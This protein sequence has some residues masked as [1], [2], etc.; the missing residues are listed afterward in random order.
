MYGPTTATSTSVT[1]KTTPTSPFRL[2]SS[3][4][5]VAMDHDSPAA[6]PRAGTTTATGGAVAVGGVM[7]DS[8]R[9]SWL[10]IKCQIGSAT[11]DG[12]HQRARSSFTRGSRYAYETSTR[13]L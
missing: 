4:R 6:S 10:L 2:R 7:V 13:M 11:S 9:G 12:C 3:R 8:L 1:R 5:V